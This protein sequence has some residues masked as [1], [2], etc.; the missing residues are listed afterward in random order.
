VRTSH[1]VRH[2]DLRHFSK[3]RATRNKIGDH[4]GVRGHPTPYQSSWK[5]KSDGTYPYRRYDGCL[6]GESLRSGSKSSGGGSR[7]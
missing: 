1:D 7:R 5:V 3:I 4:P 6:R 2:H